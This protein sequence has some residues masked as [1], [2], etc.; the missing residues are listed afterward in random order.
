MSLAAINCTMDIP[1]PSYQ[2]DMDASAFIANSTATNG[3]HSSAL[4]VSSGIDY[5]RDLKDFAPPPSRK[6]KMS[7]EIKVKAD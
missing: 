5:Q 3:A 6:R 1:M 4:S 7:E 2:S